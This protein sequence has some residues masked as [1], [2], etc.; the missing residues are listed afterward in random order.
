M[1][2]RASLT[3]PFVAARVEAHVQEP[4]GAK[5]RALK[6]R[7]GYRGSSVR[8]V[9]WKPAIAWMELATWRGFTLVPHRIKRGCIGGHGYVQTAAAVLIT[10]RSLT[11]GV[12]CRTA[13][14]GEYSTKSTSTCHTAG[15]EIE[16]AMCSRARNGKNG[17]IMDG[18]CSM[19][20]ALHLSVGRQS[21]G[22]VLRFVQV[23][24]E[25]CAEAGPLHS[26]P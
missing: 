12:G 10:G 21:G 4:V 14:S 3:L 2:A 17:V 7:A 6:G 26:Q 5:S 24:R 19:A 9:Q 18:V 13:T 23:D 20:V 25:I 16:Y 8:L 11:D 1:C 15:G 22:D